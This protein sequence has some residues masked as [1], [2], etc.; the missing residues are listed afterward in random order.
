MNSSNQV[1]KIVARKKYMTERAPLAM[2]STTLVKP[3]MCTVTFPVSS[4]ERMAS[5]RLP[6]A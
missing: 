6:M 1:N 4:C 2:S 3:M 5:R